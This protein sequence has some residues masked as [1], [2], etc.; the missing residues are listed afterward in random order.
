MY[1]LRS[2]ILLLAPAN[3]ELGENAGILNLKSLLKELVG[4]SF[5]I[6]HKFFV[7]NDCAVSLLAT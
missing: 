3:H 1:L 7:D 2:M 6:L 4:V 5:M